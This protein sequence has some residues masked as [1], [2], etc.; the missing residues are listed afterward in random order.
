[1]R[2][3]T[4]ILLAFFLLGCLPAAAQYHTTGSSPAGLRWNR[5]RSEHFDVIFPRGLDSLAR[6]YL[7]AF[8]KTRSASLAGLRIETPRMPM[9]LH[10]YDMYSNG[11]VVWAPRRLEL[12]TTP[13]GTPLFALNWEMQLAVHEGRHIG[14]MA[15]YTKG[16]YHLLNI[17]SG[18]QGSALGIGLYPSQTLMEGDA[19][20]NETDL[21]ASGRGRDPEFLKY[22]R[23]AFLAGD[24]RNYDAWRYGS[25]RKYTPGKYPFGYLM[26]STMRDN[27]KNYYATGDIMGLQVKNWWRF[28]S[29]SHLSYRRATGLTARKNWRAA[30]ARNTELWSWEYKLRAPYTPM[31]PLLVSREKV[32]TDIYNPMPLGEGTYA[33][34]GGMQFERRIVRIDSRG[35]RHFRR[36]IAGSTSALVPDSDHSFLFSEIVPDPRWEHRSWSV[37][38]RYDAEKNRFETLTR[39]SRYLNPVPSASKNEILAA[40]YKL[41][42]GSNVVIL[43]RE[44]K[45]LE[46]IPAPGNGQVTGIAP[47]HDDIFATVVTEKGM[48]LYRYDGAW[49]HVVLPQSR[50]IRDL[51]TSGDSLLY[52]VSDL[53]G[54]SNIY[55]FD[56]E[57]DLLHRVTSARFGAA[58]PLLAEDGTLYYSDY[59]H[60]GYQPVKVA[61]DSLPRRTHSF[62]NP[63]VN[64]LAERNARQASIHTKALPLQEES[65]LR[66]HID[67]LEARPYSK[68][69]HGIHIHSWAPFYANVNRLMNDMGSFDWTHFSN[70]YQ[71]LAPGASVMAQNTMGTL[72]GTAGYSYHDRHHAGHLYARYS[73]LYPVFTVTADFNERN[74]TLSSVSATPHGG[75]AFRLDTLSA[76]ALVVSTRLSVPLNFSRGGW[77]TQLQPSVGAAWTNDA[78]EYKMPGMPEKI[79]GDHTLLLTGD[80]FFSTKMSCPAARLTPRLGFG[81]Q[82]SGMTRIGPARN[83]V[84]G[85]KAWTYLPGLGKEDGFKLTYSRQY[86]P[87]DAA[88][89]SPSFNLVRRPEGFK[90]VILMNY[91]RVKFE[92]ALPVYA[93]DLN[94]G[95]FFFLKRLQLVPFVDYAFDKAH[96]QLDG[97]AIARREPTHFLSYGTAML[98]TTRLFRIGRDFDLGVLYARPHLPGERG[99]FRFILSNGL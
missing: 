55:T 71:F 66:S 88:L 37:I 73:G 96:P 72:V 42:G 68:L 6:E 78:F 53:D 41:E 9:V 28:F 90:D 10:P 95:F 82:L 97:G 31:T 46:R 12:Y 70:W 27:S 54:L 77:I 7:F 24:F 86:Q 48:G 22:F 56:P 75:T 39:R 29:V 98:I 45:L 40:E 87:D 23:A 49:K 59:D 85:L 20:Q 34:M 52:F 83:N 89:Y 14:Q 69:A 94:G 76:P 84:I 57:K 30:I 5:I 50:M 38:R 21:T 3:K 19:V 8:E 81:L 93:G 61:L 17:L 26:T 4:A 32:Y 80:I 65:L 60:Q 11:M 44:G 1:M 51:R 91:H 15:H 58:N 36:P 92:Y 62:W 79:A 43:S 33:A 16:V 47:L 35:R 18:E 2:S 13:P 64:E 63:Y 25:F 67:S 99:S 74:R